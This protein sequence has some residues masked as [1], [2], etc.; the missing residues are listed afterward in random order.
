M[1]NEN[2]SHYRVTVYNV[3]VEMTIVTY[4]ETVSLTGPTRQHRTPRYSVYSKLFFVTNLLYKVL[5][6]REP[7][8]FYLYTLYRL[9]SARRTLN[10]Y[11]YL[12]DSHMLS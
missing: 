12:Q 1:T 11:S 8:R 2:P 6:K 9:L 4:T 7:F 5:T 10:Q 3:T